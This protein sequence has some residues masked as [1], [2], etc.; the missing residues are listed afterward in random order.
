MGSARLALAFLNSDMKEYWRVGFVQA[1][2][3]GL[4]SAMKMR[5]KIG[6]EKEVASVRNN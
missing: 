3:T 1:L 2:V 4:H 5:I 6:E